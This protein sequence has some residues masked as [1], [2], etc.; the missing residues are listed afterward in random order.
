M[1]Q[2][3]RNKW[4]MQYTEDDFKG[5]PKKWGLRKMTSRELKKISES[6]PCPNCSEDLRKNL[7]SIELVVTRFGWKIHSDGLAEPDGS[8]KFV[9]SE[10]SH[11]ECSNCDTMFTEEELKAEGITLS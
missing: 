4:S 8:E 5:Q 9:G 2:L 11:F 7:K 10:L 3:F 6:F 1:F